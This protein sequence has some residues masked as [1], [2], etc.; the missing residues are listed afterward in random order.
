MFEDDNN[1]LDMYETTE[2]KMLEDNDEENAI[3]RNYKSHNSSGQHLEFMGTP[4]GIGRCVIGIVILIIGIIISVVVGGEQETALECFG[5]LG[6]I[7]AAI[8]GAITTW[9]SS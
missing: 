5:A 6:V 8:F 3:N 1:L 9:R 2:Q 7:I 4:V